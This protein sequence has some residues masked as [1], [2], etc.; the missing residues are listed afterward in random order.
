M[1]VTPLCL[2][3]VLL[4]EPDVFTDSR[5]FF[6]ETFHSGKYAEQGLPAVFFQ[7]N[8]YRSVRGVFRGVK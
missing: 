1:R 6:T 7:D 8:H 5:G 3:E 2:P 4:I